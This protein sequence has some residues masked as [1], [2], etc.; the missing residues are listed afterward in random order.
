MSWIVSGIQYHKSVQTYDKSIDMLKWMQVGLRVP[1]AGS[2]PLR[3]RQAQSRKFEFFQKKWK[4]RWGCGDRTF[5]LM[6]DLVRRSS[7]HII[8]PLGNHLNHRFLSQEF[9]GACQLKS[10]GIVFGLLAKSML[11]LVLLRGCSISWITCISPIANFERILNAETCQQQ[12]ISPKNIHASSYVRGS[13]L[14]FRL[15]RYDR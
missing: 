11:I 8:Y 7:C 1:G 15:L 9:Q 6:N 14:F 10:F 5:L 13:S 3:E 2:V 12:I 4:S